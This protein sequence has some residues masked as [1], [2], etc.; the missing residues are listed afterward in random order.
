[1]T[2]FVH[3]HSNL[4]QFNSEPFASLPIFIVATFTFGRSYT[5][6]LIIKVLFPKLRFVL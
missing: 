3:L 5:V 4:E 6:I 1:M 2:F